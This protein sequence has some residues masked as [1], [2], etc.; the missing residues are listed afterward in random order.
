MSVKKNILI[1]D[2]SKKN[3]H[4]LSLILKD[5]IV[6]EQTNGEDAF[7]FIREKSK[8]IKA[9]LLNINMPGMDGFELMEHLKE[10]GLLERIPI[11][12]ISNNDYSEYE[13]KCLELGA[14]DVIVEPFEAMIVKN[15]L[16]NVIELYEHKHNL[17]ALINLETK[18]FRI[19]SEAR[20]DALST[21]VEYRSLE[22]GQHI[23]RIRLFTELLANKV[24]QLCP[25]YHLTPKEVEAITSA[26]PLHDIGKIAI[27]DSIL[28]KPSL[29]TN[30][31]FEVMKTHTIKG[32]EIAK[33][34]QHIDDNE[35]MSYS[36]NVCRFHHERWD[37][38]GYPDQLAG[39]EIP[40]C[41]QIVSICDVYD[42]LTAHRVYKEPYSH[43]LAIK[44]IH[45]GECG[46]FSDEMMQCFDKV[47][48]GFEKIKNTYA[49]EK[50]NLIV[51]DQSKLINSVNKPNYIEKTPLTFKEAS[52]SLKKETM[53]R[54]EL[55]NAIPG[56]V[57]KI[58]INDNFDIKLASDGFYKLGGYSSRDFQGEHGRGNGI[59]MVY[60]DDI[61]NVYATVIKQIKENKPICVEFRV[62]KKDGSIAWLSGHGSRIIE[63]D[64]QQVVQAVFIDITDNKNMQEKLL[65]L[66]NKVPGGIVK[67]NVNHNVSVAYAN[68]GFYEIFDLTSNEFFQYY[69]EQ[70]SMD[71]IYKNDRKKVINE[72]KN[73]IKSGEEQ[74]SFDCRVLV[75]NNEIVWYLVNGSRSEEKDGSACCQCLFMDVT[76][77]KHLQEVINTSEERYRIIVEQTQDII[78]EWDMENQTMYTS[79]AFERKFSYGLPT[80]HFFDE[81]MKT[82]FIYEDDIP[83]FMNLRKKIQEGEGL[84]TEFRIRNQEGNYI[85]CRIKVTMIF[86]QNNIAVRAI[87][88]ITDVN[89]Y[90]Q[91]NALLKEKAH[92]DLLSGLLNKVTMENYI[93][94]Y[95]EEEGKHYNHAMLLVDIDD[96]KEINDTYGHLYG[97][98]AIQIIGASLKKAFRNDDIVG[99]AGGDE[100]VVFLKNVSSKELV[101]E[102]ARQLEMILKQAKEELEVQGISESVGIALYPNDANTFVDLFKC[103]DKALYDAKKNGKSQI[104][105]YRN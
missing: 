12:L 17:E 74:F 46:C 97:D 8:Q 5:Y 20:L 36:C 30:E 37:G 76:S 1:V 50:A 102:K 23:K 56:G 32:W 75:K 6:S 101:I 64:G 4:R 89:E 24:M 91:E 104:V 61:P 105:F 82:D 103:A 47:S 73:F 51:N 78:F 81:M 72:I 34:F 93:K 77:S 86:D 59:H 67:F 52:N 22:S 15:R 10:E 96:F 79:P 90:I 54:D 83:T 43:K 29:L 7:A 18:N 3:R 40:L 25:R 100:F 14:Y 21:M 60:P 58:V 85:W 70:T 53:E 66:M 62:R 33:R 68:D 9:I 80:H 65:T 88:T 45:D 44:M 84:E 99:R 42:A 71:F 57:A 11:I 35:F 87:G 63:E 95:L 69:H 49:D 92:H 94:K 26:S 41:A 19:Q 55:I 38:G 31:E 2:N 13:A 28:L 16:R 48:D 27:P 39:D 98:K